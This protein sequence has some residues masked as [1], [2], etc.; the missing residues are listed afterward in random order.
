MNVFLTFDIEVWCPSWNDLDANFPKAFDRYVF[1]RSRHGGYA[2][3]KT[4]E[5]LN[6]HGLH[7]VFFVEPLFSGRFGAE[8]LATIVDLIRDAE[9][10]VQLHLHPE[11]TDE[12]EPPLIPNNGLKRQHLSY[13][14][15]AEQTALIGHGLRML[16]EVGV[17]SVNA[18]RT[19]S[20]AADATTFDALAAN[21]IP[22]DSSLDPS[23][24]ISAPDIQ[25]VSPAFA[26]VRI[27][28]VSE[29][30]VTVFKDGLGKLRHAQV[31]ACSTSELARALDQRA[32][33]SAADFVIYSH[34]FEMLKPGSIEPDWIVV[35]RFERL[36]A[37]LGRTREWPTIGFHEA[38][39]VEREASGP[40]YS[41][42]GILPTGIRL[43]EQAIRMIAS[44]G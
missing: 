15:L 29:Y 11:W 8:H 24:G 4:L 38:R 32:R 26:P 42:V 39:R 2:L 13:Y 25:R 10:E 12:I 21:G 19:G 43:L 30:P 5:I 36:C 14:D 33:A 6:R 40:R 41:S 31:G 9:Q 16:S 1:G 37:L 22:F 44:R 20:F 23:S 17:H 34:N 18:F 28:S 7:G 27:G 3:P 35:R